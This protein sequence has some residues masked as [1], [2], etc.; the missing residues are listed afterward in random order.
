MAIIY[1]YP[2]IKNLKANDRFI[3]SQ[4]DSQNNP[5]KTVTLTQLANFINSTGFSGFGTTDTLPIWKD[6]TAGILGDSV[7]KQ[8]PAG[9]TSNVEITPSTSGGSIS[10]TFT[11]GSGGTLK[12]DKTGIAGSFEF[13]CEDG[14]F[15]T[16][17]FRY[18]SNLAVGRN[19]ISPNVTWQ[20][21]WR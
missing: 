14:G 4:M 7:I 10:T 21:V 18:E 3:V 20:T 6:G 9:T 16:S 15:Y 2:E 19:S 8:A 11:L 17:T 12:A 13:R 5:T 1:T